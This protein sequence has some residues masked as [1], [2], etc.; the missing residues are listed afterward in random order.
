MSWC[1][2][3]LNFYVFLFWCIDFCPLFEF[4]FIL[5]DKILFKLN[6]IWSTFVIHNK[7]IIITFN[8]GICVYIYSGVFLMFLTFFQC[9]YYQSDTWVVLILELLFYVESYDRF[10]I[11]QF[12][13]QC[14]V[15]SYI[16]NKF[17][18]NIVHYSDIDYLNVFHLL[19][20]CAYLEMCLEPLVFFTIIF[21]WVLLYCVDRDLYLHLIWHTI[22]E[23]SNL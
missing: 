19:L 17:A 20:F 6:S 21:R 22:Y 10:D 15:L 3:G 23:C 11:S 4:C 2:A 5:M 1:A 13:N 18:A 7:S 12:L 9:Y 14:C 16:L 8:P